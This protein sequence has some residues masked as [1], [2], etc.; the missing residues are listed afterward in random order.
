MKLQIKTRSLKKSEANQLR[1]NGFIPAVIYVRSESSEPIAVSAVELEAHLRKIKPGLLSTARFKLID[2]EGRER[3]SLI[4][5]IQ[6]NPTNY[7]IMH[8]DFEELVEDRPIKVNVPIVMKGVED[9]AGVRLG[10]MLQQFIR[11]FKIS[12]LP[13]DIPL[14]FELNVQNL[15]LNQA[16]KLK[17]I[18]LKGS[19]KAKG[20]LEPVVVSVKKS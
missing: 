15:G 19:V 7:A 17:D 16:L 8:I 12:G 10:G 4:K 9:C 5:D 14:A 13:K 11:S 6:Y 18:P 2:E 3:P 1:R 20:D